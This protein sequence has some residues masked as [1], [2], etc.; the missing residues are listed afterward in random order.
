MNIE[1]LHY[2]VETART[3]SISATALNL[4]VSQSAVSKSIL[5]MEQDLGFPLFI[6]SRAGIV[7]TPAGL[8]LIQKATEIINKVH[9]FK[10]IADEYGIK[11]KQDIKL[12]SVPMFM[13]ILNHSLEIIMSENPFTQIDVAEKSSKEIIYEVRQNIVD[14][15]FLILNDE[16]RNDPELEYQVLTTSNTF[17]CIKKDSPLAQKAA[18]TPEEVVDQRIVIYNGSIKEWFRNYF[19]DS[20][21][22]KYSLVT[23][24][25]ES[26]KSRVINGTSISFL[27]ELTINNHSF[28]DSGEIVAVP[29]LMNGKQIKMQIA[30]VKKKKDALTKTTKDLLRH[31]KQD[32][33]KNGS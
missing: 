14:I 8:K 19:N 29:L 23:N 26:I 18:L 11:A 30:W 28:L 5:R 27:S 17:V 10:E 6:R 16:I 7:P 2:L 25:I 32:I 12:A 9:E 22:F 20:D 31:L 15:G 33:E 21:Y 3:G 13:L 1:Q 4:H 24:N